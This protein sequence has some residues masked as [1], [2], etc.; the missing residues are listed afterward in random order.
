RRHFEYCKNSFDRY[1]NSLG[2]HALTDH[3]GEAEI[4][5]KACLRAAAKVPACRRTA[6]L[7]LAGQ[8]VAPSAHNWSNEL[9]KSRCEGRASVWPEM[10]KVSKVK[11][12]VCQ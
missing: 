2:C 12:A 3:R 10:P 11:N 9:Y 6:R 7:A 5:S 4:G 1:W 8:A